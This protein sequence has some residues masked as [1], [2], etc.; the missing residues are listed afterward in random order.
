MKKRLDQA[1]AEF[2]LVS[3]R[4]QAES[5]IR[6]GKVYV[7]NKVITKP[8]HFIKPDSHIEVR[9]DMQYVSR[10]AY[11]LE[12]VAQ[13]FKLNFKN[14]VVLDVGSSTG[15]FTDYALQQGAKKSICVEVGTEQLHQR[16]RGNERIE[17]HEKTD[18]RDIFP[19][20]IDTPDIVVIDVSFISL[21]DVLPHIASL[22]TVRTPATLVVAMAKPQFEV[23]I[24]MKNKG[25]IKNERLRRDILTD[26]ELKMKKHFIILDKA[27]SGVSGEK[28]NQE[29]FYLMKLIGKMNQK[30][31]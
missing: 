11:K 8:G 25:V 27:D 23:G 10:A 2:K 30:K 9:V 7:D 22:L 4:S 18:I 17:L 1:L 28:G 3:T 20:E 6:L 14:K 5:F 19:G 16:L 29:R 15:G 31:N 13:L 24:K 26:L 12:S 21:N